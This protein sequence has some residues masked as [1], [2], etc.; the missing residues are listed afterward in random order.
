MRV[1]KEGGKLTSNDKTWSYLPHLHVREREREEEEGKAQ[2]GSVNNLKYCCS[3]PEQ[4]SL[5]ETLLL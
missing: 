4:G 2:Q 3:K 5:L 1:I